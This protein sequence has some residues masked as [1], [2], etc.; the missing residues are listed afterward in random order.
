VAGDDR[1]K[2]ERS[3]AFLSDGFQN[4]PVPI[5]TLLDEYHDTPEPR[6]SDVVPP[7]EPEGV[8]TRVVHSLTG[9]HPHDAA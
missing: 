6:D 8:V 2:M 4:V 9:K 5:K 1:R 7:P 3:G